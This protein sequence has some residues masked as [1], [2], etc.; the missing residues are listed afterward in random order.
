MKH[1][2]LCLTILV[3]VFSACKKGTTTTKDAADPF[4]GTYTVQEKMTQTSGGSSTANETFQANISK[5]STT[6]VTIHESRMVKP[7]WSVDG[8]TFTVTNDTFALGTLNGIRYG[9]DSLVVNYL[10]GAGSSVYSVNQ[11]WKK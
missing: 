4:V 1:Y 2:T 7:V 10:Y 3:L 8:S 11:V 6:S 9:N 5:T